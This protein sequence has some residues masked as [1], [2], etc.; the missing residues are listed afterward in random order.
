MY[1][2]W[3]EL[4]IKDPIYYEK[5]IVKALENAGFRIV[6]DYDDINEKHYIVT[7][8]VTTK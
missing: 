8:E 4:I 5:E 2:K 7:R 3:A 1:K 6:I